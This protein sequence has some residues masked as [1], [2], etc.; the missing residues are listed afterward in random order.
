MDETEAWR[1]L[2]TLL[3]RKQRRHRGGAG[4]SEVEALGRTLKGRAAL[5]GG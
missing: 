4:G 1:H 3:L 2:R 5:R